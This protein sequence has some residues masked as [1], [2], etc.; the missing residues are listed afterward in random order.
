VASRTIGSE[1]PL[2]AMSGRS[3]KVRSRHGRR[4]RRRPRLFRQDRRGGAGKGGPPTREAEA[5]STC[6]LSSPTNRSE[7]GIFSNHQIGRDRLP[8][9]HLLEKEHDACV[10]ALIARRLFNALDKSVRRDLR[11]QSHIAGQAW[12]LSWGLSDA[13]RPE[14]KESSRPYPSIRTPLAYRQRESKPPP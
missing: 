10:A 1:A 5:D 12:R 13:R 4:D 8:L 7:L 11:F 2:M 14:W 3:S 9:P 6:R